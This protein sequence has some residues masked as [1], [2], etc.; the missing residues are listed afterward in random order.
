MTKPPNPRRTGGPRSPEGKVATSTNAIKNGVYTN[1]VLLPGESI[2]D[3]EQ[4]VQTLEKDF[5]VEDSIERLLVR[6][7]ANVVWKIKRLELIEKQILANE[8]G[9]PF[10]ASELFAMGFPESDGVSYLLDLPE[11]L[12]ASDLS[13]VIQKTRSASKM[14]AAENQKTLLLAIK[15]DRP[16]IFKVIEGFS[17]GVP[18]SG[19]PKNIKVV[20]VSP[21][22]PISD[23]ELQEIDLSTIDEL[24]NA[25]IGIRDACILLEERQSELEE[26]KGLVKMQRLQNLAERSSMSRPHDDLLRSMHKLLAELRKQKDWR[27]VNRVVDMQRAD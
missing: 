1:T 25:L 21:G 26:L 11:P 17:A 12:A 5:Q 2:E 8:L 3:Y 24:S 27:K 20:L 7:I 18:S 19:I 22:K 9:R 6:Q 10:K 23:E 13:Y 15:D 16:D 4:I 14:D